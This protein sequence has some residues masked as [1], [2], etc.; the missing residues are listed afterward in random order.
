ML[1]A[2]FQV[3]SSTI[4][5]QAAMKSNFFNC[6]SVSLATLILFG[7]AQAA[8]AFGTEPHT[9]LRSNIVDQPEQR[10]QGKA[11]Q[12]KQ[13]YPAHPVTAASQTTDSIQQ[14]SVEPT[15]QVSNTVGGL[16]VTV[17]FI[18]YILAGLQY[19]KRRAHRAA[20]LLEQIETL[21]RIWRMNPQQR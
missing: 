6:I 4:G 15:A 17:L 10:K 20:V 14:N 11:S 5:A 19:R 18:S 2:Y 12:I 8:F 16:F 1:V 3:L 21:E 9:E 7:S 13:N